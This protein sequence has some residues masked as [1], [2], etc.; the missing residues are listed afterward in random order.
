MWLWP[1]QALHGLTFTAAHLGV[2][3]FV[4]VAAPP[5]LAATA[6]GLTGAL[7]GGVVMAGASFAAAWAYP[8][9]G[10]DA[11]WIGAALA[12]AGALA[13]IALQR[14]WGGGTLSVDR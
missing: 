9:L 2:M 4:Q 3:A 7:A 11:Y 13:A 14:S 8:A 1:L 6:Q 12:A 5:Q 10:A